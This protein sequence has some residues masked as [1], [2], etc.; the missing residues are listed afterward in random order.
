MTSSSYLPFYFRRTKVLC[1]DQGFTEHPSSWCREGAE[2]LPL[3]RV[4]LEVPGEGHGERRDPGRVGVQAT[5]THRTP[6]AQSSRS[7]TLEP[8]A[9]AK[10]HEENQCHTQGVVTSGTTV[11]FSGRQQLAQ[12]TA[13]S[14]PPPP[15]TP[16]AGGY[17]GGPHR[18]EPLP[19]KVS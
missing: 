12:T 7:Q 10:P 9:Q 15:L 16:A 11:S 19:R 17:P 8:E 18:G 6:G 3:E 2:V 14:P 1:A 13:F 4:P 5:R